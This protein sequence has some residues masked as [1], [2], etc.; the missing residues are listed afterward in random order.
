VEHLKLPTIL[1]NQTDLARVIR[2]LNGL[3]DF[4][5]EAKIRTGGTSMMMPK[6]SRILDQLARD[7][8][9]NLLDEAERSQLFA[10]LQ[11]IFKDA[12]KM[13]LSFAAEPSFKALE[14]VLIWLRENIHPHSLVQV[15]LQPAIAGGCV[16]RT[17]NKVFDMSL[18]SN[19]KKQES[20][21]AQLIKGA[22][23]G[24]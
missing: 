19:L 24:R 5:A 20:Y 11:E 12:P 1:I 9:I 13:H 6:L 4:F 3:N 18:R 7:N 10:G 2:E 14:R 16:L 22:A 17:S 8:N 15:G 23:D 21:L